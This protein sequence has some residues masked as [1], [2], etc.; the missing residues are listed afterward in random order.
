LEEE[1]FIIITVIGFWIFR[2]TSWLFIIC[3]ILWFNYIESG[4]IH[5]FKVL[6]R[7]A[8]VKRL[9]HH[10]WE[11]A[12]T[13]GVMQMTRWCNNQPRK[14][15]GRPWHNKVAVAVAVDGDWARVRVRARAVVV[16]AKAV[17]RAVARV[18]VAVVRAV[19]RAVARAV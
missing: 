9:I 18:V 5:W 12:D 4:F 3:L 7:N 8:L 15:H 17:A 14:R 11:C 19:A 16:V 1:N 6:V 10:C 2:V 13:D